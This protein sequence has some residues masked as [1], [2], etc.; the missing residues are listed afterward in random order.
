MS[1]ETLLTPSPRI[2][3]T[4]FMTTGKGTYTAQKGYY[5]NL[6]MEKAFCSEKQK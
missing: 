1:S 6:Q 5:Y 2:M 4:M 3:V